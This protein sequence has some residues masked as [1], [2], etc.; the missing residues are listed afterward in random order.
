L[1]P[2]P[3][4]A[5]IDATRILAAIDSAIG[6]AVIG[7]DGELISTAGRIDV[8]S[9]RAEC[10]PYLASLGEVGGPLALGAPRSWATGGVNM[11][12][13]HRHTDGFVVVVRPT[14]QGPEK[15]LHKLVRAVGIGS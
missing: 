9:V 13:V 12:Y 6:A 11:T 14:G 1:K 5:A 4:L 3:A 10:A 15:I 7:P 8:A 2:S